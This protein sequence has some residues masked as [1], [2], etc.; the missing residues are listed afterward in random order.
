[1][2]IQGYFW[3]MEVYNLSNGQL[4]AVEIIALKPA[5]TNKEV[6]KSVGVSENT[7]GAWRKNPEFINCCFERFRE[8]AGTRLMT[9]MDAMFNEAEEGNVPAARLILEHYNKLNPTVNITIDSPFERFL[10]AG[11]INDA[12]ILSPVEVLEIVDAQP[13]N[14]NDKVMIKTQEKQL[15]KSISGA[16]KDQKRKQSKRERYALRQRALKVGMEPLPSGRP[17]PEQRKK[18]LKQLEK[19]ERDMGIT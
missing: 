2:S 8:I 14:S 18:W 5:V 1:M 12:Q 6:A 16:Y 15:K 7:M 10:K 11:N 19:K 3:A 13:N 17:K 9:V 4:E